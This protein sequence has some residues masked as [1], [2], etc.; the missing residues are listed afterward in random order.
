MKIFLLWEKRENSKLISRNKS[1]ET[2]QELNGI[3]AIWR[4]QTYQSTDVI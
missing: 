3:E 4:S 2:K 1:T